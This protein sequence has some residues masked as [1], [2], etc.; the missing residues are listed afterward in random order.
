MNRKSSL[1]LTLLLAVGLLTAVFNIVL[2]IPDL[3]NTGLTVDEGSPSTVVSNIML[4]VED[5]DDLGGI[6][7]YTVD[8]IPV[9]GTL[10][11]NGVPLANGEIFTQTDINNSLLTYIHDGSEGTPDR[12]VFTVKNMTGTISATQ[13]FTLTINPINDPPTAN[14]DTIYLEEGAS[15]SITDEGNTSLLDNDTD[16]DNNHAD[17]VANTV[18]VSGPNFAA[19]LAI[20]TTGTFTYTHDDSENFNDT[21]DYRMC[22]LEPVCDDGTVTVVITPVVDIAPTVADQILSV[23]ENRGNGFNFGPISATDTEVN[24]GYDTITYSIIG[25]N[26]GNAFNINN[27]NG[28]LIVANPAQLNHEITD[29]IT[30]TVQVVDLAMLSDTAVITVNINDINEPPNIN[31]HS[32]TKPENSPNGTVI[33]DMSA[34]ASDPD[35]GDT[36]TYSITIDTLSAFEI[37]PNS[38]VITVTDSSKLNIES[39]SF[40]HNITVEVE[41]VGGLTDA[42]NVT[43]KLTDVNEAPTIGNDTFDVDEDSAD[44]ANVGLI[45]TANDPDDGDSIVF[46]ITAGDPGGVFAIGLNSGQITVDDSSLLDHEDTPQFSLTVEIEDTGNLT[47]TAT[48]TIDVNDI[49]EAPVVAP[50]QTFS[51]P[52][53]SINGYAVGTVNADDEDDGDSFTFSTTDSTFAVDLNSGE[54]TVIDTAQLDFETTT[55]FVVTIEADDGDLVGSEDITITLTNVNEAPTIPNGQ[56]F[57]I[58]GF[59]ENGTAVGQVNSSD[60]DAGDD[61]TF[62]IVGGNPNNAFVIDGNSGQ[63]TVGNK[64]QLDFDVTPQFNLTVRATDLLGKTDDET[65]VVNLTKPPIFVLYL[66]LV[67]N[68]YRADEP[69]NICSESYAIA[70]NTTFS[71]LPEDQ[72]DWY[73]FTIGNNSNVTVTLSNYVP[74]GQ[75]LVYS[76]NCGAGNLILL[77]SNGSQST[78]R[79]LNLG[80]LAAGTYFVRVFTDAPFNSTQ[81]YNLHVSV[82]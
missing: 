73:A 81:S 7:T 42:A 11:L 59:S 63:I 17:L 13:P 68:N 1:L 54:I 23:D 37:D 35:D 9:S 53:N 26:Q 65:V 55:P 62:T 12:F 38:G 25:G 40:P 78:T 74:V 77:Q 56:N 14:P 50:N 2:A 60:P 58:V 71:F 44:A 3:T 80:N 82:P 48:I 69:N 76:G 72:E 34:F 57:T 39:G 66:P 32:F 6:F 61:V 30:I 51:I 41:D 28:R 18:P 70:T 5:T 79:V 4:R 47:D 67:L 20:S 22:D 31:A 33:G 45:A 10:N 36:F 49:N 16:P 75:I 64:N 19:S 52:E 8:T 27:G 43:I 29:S 46:S 21:F 15:I 24:N